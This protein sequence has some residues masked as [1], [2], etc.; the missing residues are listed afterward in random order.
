MSAYLSPQQ[1]NGDIQSIT[2][3]YERVSEQRGEKLEAPEWVIRELG[4]HYVD[5][6]NYDKAIDLFK[7]AITKYPQTPDAYNGLAYGYERMDE[8][9]KSLES[10]N[11]A[12]ALSTPE[13]DGHQVYL[14]R[15]KRLQSLLKE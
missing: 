5:I 3:Y 8:Y 12:L 15:Q 11:K 14:S 10:V 2:K 7:H 9:E 13:H 1:F 4:Y 6:Q